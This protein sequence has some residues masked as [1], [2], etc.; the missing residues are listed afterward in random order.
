MIRGFGG[1]LSLLSLPAPDSLTPKTYKSSRVIWLFLSIPPQIFTVLRL[2]LMHI[3]NKACIFTQICVP[4]YS[5]DD[6]KRKARSV[7]RNDTIQ[8]ISSR[9]ESFSKSTENL[10]INKTFKS[11]LF[12]YSI[13]FHSYTHLSNFR[14]D[15]ILVV[16]EYQNL[17]ISNF[18]AENKTFVLI[19]NKIFFHVCYWVR[20]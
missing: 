1:T 7:S 9:R 14:Y 8:V 11:Y 6:W 3:L 16:N 18:Y 12:L 15:L 2:S 10:K 20:G 13:C 17:W 4:S 19:L 5:H